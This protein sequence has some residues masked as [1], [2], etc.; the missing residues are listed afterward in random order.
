MKIPNVKN[1]TT[2]EVVEELRRTLSKLVNNFNG[3]TLADAI[4]LQKDI[5]T[6]ISTVVY[7]SMVNTVE[8]EK[9][10]EPKG[11]LLDFSMT[12]ISLASKILRQAE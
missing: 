4:I 7:D 2:K 12:K 5:N 10:S 6:L 8:P 3:E 9:P 11:S 1:M